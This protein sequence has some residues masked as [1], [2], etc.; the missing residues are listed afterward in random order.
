MRFKTTDYPIFMEAP[1]SESAMEQIITASGKDRAS[2]E[3]EIDFY[4]NVCNYRFW[5]TKARGEAT[6]HDPHAQRPVRG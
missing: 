3:R 1:A 2:I 5:R 4:Q 6:E